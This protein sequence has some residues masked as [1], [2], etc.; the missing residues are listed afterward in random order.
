[1]YKST[2]NT[3]YKIPTTWL[4][5]YSLLEDADI[6]VVVGVEVTVVIKKT[7]G[8]YTH[9]FTCTSHCKYSRMQHP[10]IGC[11]FLFTVQNMHYTPGLM[12][13][14]C[15]AGRGG[16]TICSVR[17]T[18]QIVPLPLHPHRGSCLTKEPRTLN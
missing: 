1:M 10:C 7:S 6:K 5:Y 17:R 9:R 14:N 12:Y 4:Y 18:L 15:G 16:R 8:L 3:N 2:V 13:H 11:I